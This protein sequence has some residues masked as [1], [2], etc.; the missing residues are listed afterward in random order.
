[1][2]GVSAMKSQVAQ[3][4]IIPN[5]NKDLRFASFPLCLS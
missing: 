5:E 3:S 2:P 1:M 4:N